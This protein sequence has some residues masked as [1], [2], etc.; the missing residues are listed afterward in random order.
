MTHHLSGNIYGIHD[1]ELM[2]FAPDGVSLADI[3]RM[4][5]PDREAFDGT[6]NAGLA[7][8]KLEIT[9]PFMFES[10][11]APHLAA[12]TVN[13]APSQDDDIGGRGALDKTFDETPGK[14]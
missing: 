9:M 1:T 10:R 14:K 11:L 6:S 13:N 2:E 8:A 4:Q 3:M 5:G 7:A 12:V